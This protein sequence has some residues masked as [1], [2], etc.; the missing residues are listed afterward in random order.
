MDG[1]ALAEA[2]AGSRTSDAFEMNP[3]MEEEDES[4]DAHALG[5]QEN[6]N[7]DVKENSDTEVE[8][9]ETVEENS[10]MEVEVTT[11]TNRL[12]TKMM[13]KCWRRILIKRTRWSQR[14]RTRIMCGPRC[15]R[16]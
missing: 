7:E 13:R 3:E 14:Q 5:Q 2:N 8:V 11:H 16:G 12:E 9:T 10:E 15:H 1:P 6:E 4:A